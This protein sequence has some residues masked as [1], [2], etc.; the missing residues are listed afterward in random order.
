MAKIIFKS[1]YSQPMRLEK[2]EPKYDT[3]GKIVNGDDIK[4]I[5]QKNGRDIRYNLLRQ[6]LLL[7]GLSKIGLWDKNRNSK[8]YNQIVEYTPCMALSMN[9]IVHSKEDIV[10]EDAPSFSNWH[11]VSEDY[12]YANP[13]GIYGNQGK[14]ITM[15]SKTKI[16]GANINL[17]ERDNKTGEYKFEG[18][19]LTNLCSDIDGTLLIVQGYQIEQM[20]S[21]ATSE[22][23][24]IFGDVYSEFDYAMAANYKNLY[25]YLKDI[26]AN[27]INCY[28]PYV[29]PNVKEYVNY[30]DEGL[31]RE[32][33][34]CCKNRK[35]PK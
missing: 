34:Y 2:I 7:D 23:D 15:G 22:F 8:P 10:P 30:Y 20:F 18:F 11:L 27:K 33:I 5:I 32:L 19:N 28:N 31:R 35:L 16:L 1:K 29:E 21:L 4:E 17:F 14:L 25:N 3:E 6:K 13:F 26:C 9:R 12:D 24:I